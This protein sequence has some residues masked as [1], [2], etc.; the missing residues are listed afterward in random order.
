MKEKN[1]NRNAF[2]ASNKKEYTDQHFKQSESD[3]KEIWIDERER[4]SEKL[5]NQR[6]RR[7]DHEYLEQSKPEKDDK[8]RPSAKRYA[9]PSHEMNKSRIHSLKIFMNVFHI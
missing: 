1:C 7:R 6:T 3:H 8:D 2:F 5:H 4:L 9:E